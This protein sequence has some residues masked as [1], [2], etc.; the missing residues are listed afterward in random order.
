MEEELQ[1]RG[2][3][4]ILFEQAE[5]YRKLENISVEVLSKYNYQE[6]RP[7]TFEDEKLFKRTIGETTDIVEKQ[8][9]TFTDK[10]GRRLALRPEG[11]AGVVRAYIENSLGKITSVTK[12]FYLGQ[13][14]R[15]E[16]PQK[17]RYREFYQ[18][19]A[20]YFG[21]AHP[22]ADVEILL[23]NMEIF[24]KSGLKDKVEL[25]INSLG[26][27]DCRQKYRAE[28]LK[29]INSISKDL[30]TDCQNRMEKNP[31]RVLDCKDDRDKFKDL[32]AIENYLCDGC[33]EHFDGVQ[34]LLDSGDCKYKVDRYLVRGLDYYTRTVFEIKSTEKLGA[35]D[36]VSAGGRYDT[37]VEQLGGES[38]PACGFAI[39]VDRTIEL[40]EKTGQKVKKVFIA[41]AG[42]TGNLGLAGQAIKIA[43]LLRKNDIFTEGP[44]PD[45]S[46]K[47]QMRLSNS[48]NSSWT[49]I[50]GEEELNKN[51]VI[52]KDMTGQSQEEIPLDNLVADLLG[53]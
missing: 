32:P 6:I 48:L 4:D 31:L 9:Y 53:R 35:Q 52:M 39:G 17:G 19:G 44:Y 49:V 15:Y 21:N 26:C 8:M 42:L 38:V 11:T 1:S 23:L 47:A 28:L 3:R 51:T 46:L 41:I 30:C 10:K 13:M 45:K 7:P 14:F 33:K 37:L 18:I 29:S 43:R 2:R 40:M 34:S 5:L 22:V 12:L 36:A 16:R 24:E 27:K 25:Y 20:E 50:I